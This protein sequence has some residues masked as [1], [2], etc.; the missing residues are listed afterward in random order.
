MKAVIQRV[1]SGSVSVQGTRISEIGY[2][3]VILVGI[4]EGDTEADIEQFVEKVVNMRI[5]QDGDKM[6]LSILDTGGSILLISQFT[7]CADLSYGRRPS[8][9]R[10]MKPQGAEVLYQKAVELFEKAE[11]PVKT[12]KFGHYM[13]VTIANDG[14]VTIVVDTKNMS[15]N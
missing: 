1:S 11:V 7:L 8:F 10:A 5:M 2:G 6:N 15:G 13:D 3:Y 9:Q 12:G 14:P 4:Y